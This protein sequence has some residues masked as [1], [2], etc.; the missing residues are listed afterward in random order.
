MA[1]DPIEQTSMSFINLKRKDPQEPSRQEPAIEADIAR[2]GNTPVLRDRIAYQRT[3]VVDVP[4]EK[5]RE[6]RVCAGFKDDPISDV[7]RILRTQVLLRMRQE[8]WTTLGVT[9]PTAGCGSTLTAVNLAIS[10]A[11]DVNHTVLLV[12]LDLRNPSLHRYFLDENVPGL[13]DYLLNDELP[14]L[15]FNPGIDRLVVL[16]GNRPIS[17]SSEFLTAP[18][19]RALFEELKAR[20]E[21]RVVIYDLPPVLS[22]DDVLVAAHHLDALM[23][24][25]EDGQTKQDELRRSLALLQGTNLLG[26]VMNKHG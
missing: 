16:P 9:S 14:Q 19:M 25:I 4:D 20:Y 18:K 2:D 7:Y 1:Q 21:Q 22:S 11:Q 5:F 23:L 3:R 17:D 12:D 8:G 13:S 6:R 24:V 10:I 26:T 15:L